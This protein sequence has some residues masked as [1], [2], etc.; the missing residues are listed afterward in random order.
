MDKS[1]YEK[2]Y[3]N[4]TSYWWFLGRRK[5]IHETV[6]SF[7]SGRNSLKYLDAGCGTGIIMKDLSEF[8]EGYG[9]DVS[10][11]A[12]EFC[13]ER[14]LKNLVEA[15][16]S[17]LPFEDG[18]FDFITVLDVLYIKWIKDERQVLSELN[19]V[20][21]KGG[22]LFSFEPAFMVLM[23]KHSA[24]VSTARRYNRKQIGDMMRAAGFKLVKSSYWNMFLFPLFLGAALLEKLLPAKNAG[25]SDMEKSLPP[26]LNYLFAGILYLESFLIDKAG[27]PF[28]TSVLTV[29]VKEKDKG[30]AL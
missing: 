15:D 9:A 19:R 20:L 28:G 22:M 5:I 24:R 16:I 23:S 8:G 12:I 17:K 13:K 10:P 25:F 29:C 2:N 7:M 3:R 18:T 11:Q 30:G 4:E 1:E 14:G 6:R 26:F 21:K 27:L